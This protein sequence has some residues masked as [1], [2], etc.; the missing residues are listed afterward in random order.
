MARFVYHS[1]LPGVVVPLIGI[2]AMIA[3]CIFLVRARIPDHYLVWLFILFLAVAA[4]MGFALYGLIDIGTRRVREI[5]SLVTDETR[6]KKT[7]SPAAGRAPGAKEDLHGMEWETGPRGIALLPH[8]LSTLFF[9][10]LAALVLASHLA[11]AR[12][13]GAA[14]NHGPAIF[15]LVSAVITLLIWA[16]VV[17]FRIS[18][19]IVTV[20]RPYAVFSRAVSFDLSEVEQVDV[21][22]WP[23][24]RKYGKCLAITLHG[25]R[26]IKYSEAG[27]VIGMVERQLRLA[28]ERSR[29]VPHP[30]SDEAVG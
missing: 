13:P 4:T 3:F 26:R 28:I 14:A 29:E 30:L 8:W 18:G 21:T 27:R 12:Q 24:D 19:Q 15:C 11:S 1:R 20:E 22:H 17:R 7:V 25:G 10:S 2:G 5:V 23:H 9:L 6:P 16:T